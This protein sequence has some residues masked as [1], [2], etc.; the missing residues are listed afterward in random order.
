MGM[1][2]LSLP[3]LA[4]AELAGQGG[5]PVSSSS[6]GQAELAVSSE[7]ELTL[8]SSTPV[9]IQGD[10]DMC[11]SCLG[12]IVPSPPGG[13]TGDGNAGGRARGKKATAE[14]LWIG[15]EGPCEYERG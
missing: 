6:T 11:P 2:M 9:H 10:D 12:P 15:C 7:G 8:P 1:T 5:P 14:L 13:G 3:R 4:S